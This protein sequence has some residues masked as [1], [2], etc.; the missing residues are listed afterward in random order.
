[1][2]TITEKTVCIFK[3]ILKKNVFVTYLVHTINNVII[4]YYVEGIG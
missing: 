1:M 3:L 2:Y 4:F